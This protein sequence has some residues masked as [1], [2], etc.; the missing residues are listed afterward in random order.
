M[1]SN[2]AKRMRIHKAMASRVPFAK[3]QKLATTL[4]AIP[5]GRGLS[6]KQLWRREQTIIEE[7]AEYRDL[8]LVG[9]GVFRYPIPK[10]SELISRYC[11][12][13]AFRLLLG[14]LH[15]RFPSTPDNPWRI[16]CNQD[17]YTPGAVLRQDNKRKTLNFYISVLEFGPVHLKSD[18][19]W[20]PFGGLRTTMCKEVVG[21]AS[22]VNA[23]VARQLTVDSAALQDGTLLR[24]GADK[25][26]TIIYFTLARYVADIAGACAMYS[27][28]GASAIFP[29]MQCTNVT[30][31]GERG[32]PDAGGWLVDVGCPNPRRFQLKSSAEIFE[33]ADILEALARRG[34][35]DDVIS[36]QGQKFGLTY[37]P[38]GLLWD[39]QLR[40]FVGVRETWTYDGAH[41][42]YCDGILQRELS[43]LFGAIDARRAFSELRALF[44]AG[45]KGCAALASNLQSA[46]SSAVS[47]KREAYFHKNGK[48][49]GQASDIIALFPCLEFYLES[50]P[51]F[52][53]QYPLVLERFRAAARLNTQ[54]WKCKISTAE[55]MEANANR[56]AALASNYSQKRIEADENCE[57]TLKHHLV[58]HLARQFVRDGV[59]IDCLAGERAHLLARATSEPVQNTRCFEKT[60]L[61][62]MLISHM[63]SVEEK[64]TFEDCLVGKTA[65]VSDIMPELGRADGA[66]RCVLWGTPLTES[67]VVWVG[68]RPDPVRVESCLD[69]HGS[70]LALI[71][72]PLVQDKPF[73]RVADLYRVGVDQMEIVRGVDHDG[74]VLCRAWCVEPDG[75]YIVVRGG[76]VY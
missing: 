42:L 59:V 3:L 46:L 28:R 41:T 22:A 1:A 55:D 23:L 20:L 18:A 30:G 40:P 65:D 61:A 63:V 50:L 26:P 57:S 25:T 32:L 62:R 44:G 43:E 10:L 15:A 56:F 38:N 27:A 68:S 76:S 34:N 67:D 17:E 54:Y 5:E 9:G 52:A 13:G 70:G 75:R 14:K 39:Q 4:R 11:E 64:K 2:D 51:N 24:I 47:S 73:N 58:H 6:R 60:M 21:G 71:V 12:L 37:N 53:D 69:I 19:C 7:V 48:L 8:P 66:N 31:A 36:E 35:H 49:P 33:Q 74:V 29:C 72:S 16:I 45:W